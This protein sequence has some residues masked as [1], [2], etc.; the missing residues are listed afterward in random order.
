MTNSPCQSTGLKFVIS[1]SVEFNKVAGI[2][3]SQTSNASVTRITQHT[4]QQD[5]IPSYILRKTTRRHQ[6]IMVDPTT[7]KIY[8]T[9]VRYV[10][11]R[12]RDIGA[13]IYSTRGA[14]Q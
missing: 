9:R 3:R 6:T 2:A 13:I 1:L 11:T 10:H 8:Y 14:W 7:V 5:I 12:A 4:I